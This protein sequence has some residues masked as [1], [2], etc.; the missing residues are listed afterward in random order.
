MPPR[1]FHSL[2]IESELLVFLESTKGPF[3]LDESENAAWAPGP[4][5]LV[6]GKAYIASVMGGIDTVRQPVPAAS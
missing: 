6:N 5:D 1:Q 3:R 4:E 2:S